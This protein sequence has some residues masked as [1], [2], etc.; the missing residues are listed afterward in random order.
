MKRFMQLLTILTVSL[1]AIVSS[2]YA[3]GKF[4]RMPVIK[5]WEMPSISSK[6][7]LTE[8]EKK[9]LNDLLLKIKPEL[10]DLEAKV[11]KEK[12]KLKN[13]IETED[14][15]ENAIMAQFD[16]LQKARV[17][18]CKKRF[19]YVLEVRKILGLKRFKLLKETFMIKAVKMMKKGH[20]HKGHHRHHG[21]WTK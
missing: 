8:Q 15:N 4:F 10:I 7:N 11:K 1:L 16:N 18:F 19:E 2:S 12:F 13:M 3:M 17:E 6:L 5:W 20:K 9:S 14:L 21:E